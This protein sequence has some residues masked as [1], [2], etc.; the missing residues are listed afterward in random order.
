MPLHDRDTFCDK[1]ET[2]NATVNP[3][4]KS[5][6]DNRET[7]ELPI[8]FGSCLKAFKG[9]WREA[10]PTGDL[11]D[12]IVEIGC[13]Q[14]KNLLE[15][16]SERPDIGFLGLD[17][18]FKRVVVSGQKLAGA[19]RQN[20]KVLLANAKSFEELF[21]ENELSGIIIFFPD[22]WSKKQRQLKNR[23]IDGSFAQVLQ[24]CLKP[25]G[26]IWF[27]TDQQEYFEEGTKHFYSCGLIKTNK[28][29][30]LG[31]RPYYS[32]FENKFRDMKIE[33]FSGVWKKMDENLLRF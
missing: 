4:V 3:Y 13:H 30:Y 17:I 1:I 26:E 21:G 11:E 2:L 32:T 25:G 7:G 33:T 6:V 8:V 28:F 18:T 16:S 12:L 9:K 23:L 24:K 19:N 14:G 27:K 31:E 10:F 29:S 22:P 15:M 5:L 20:G